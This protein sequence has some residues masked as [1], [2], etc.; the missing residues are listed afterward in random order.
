MFVESLY[1]DNFCQVFSNHGTSESL[2]PSVT[3]HFEVF[4]F[5]CHIIISSI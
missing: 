5:I 1:M 2:P 4:S 3:K